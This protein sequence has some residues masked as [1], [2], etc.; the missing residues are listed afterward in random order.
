MEK[1]NPK[2]QKELIQIYL[3][4]FWPKWRREIFGELYRTFHPSTYE[5]SFSTPTSN[6]IDMLDILEDKA[7]QE[8]VKLGLINPDTFNSFPRLDG[9]LIID[10]GANLDWVHGMLLYSVIY[11]LVMDFR[12]YQGTMGIDPNCEGKYMND[13][14]CL[15]QVYEKLYDYMLKLEEFGVPVGE[16][17]GQEKLKKIPLVDLPVEQEC[18]GRKDILNEYGVI[19]E[20]LKDDTEVQYLL[21]NIDLVKVMKGPDSILISDYVEGLREWGRY[22]MIMTDLSPFL[23]DPE[24]VLKGELSSEIMQWATENESWPPDYEEFFNQQEDPLPYLWA[25][26]QKIR[27]A[28]TRLTMRSMEQTGEPMDMDNVNKIFKELARRIYVFV[29]RGP[30]LKRAQDRKRRLDEA[31]ELNPPV[32]I[33]DVIELLHLEDPYSPI[34]LLTKGIVVGFDKDPFEDRLLVRWIIDPD[35]PEFKNMPLYPSIDAYR[36][37]RSEELLEESIILNEQSTQTIDYTSISEPKFYGGKGFVF[38]KTNDKIRPGV[39]QLVLVGPT[40]N[41][42]TISIDSFE[43]RPGKYG[44]LQVNYNVDTRGD[45]DLLF[46]KLERTQPKEKTCNFNWVTNPKYWTR[47]SW[48]K[49]LAKV[50]QDSLNQMYAQYK[51]PDGLPTPNHIKNGFINVPGTE[52]HG[53]NHGWSILNFFQTNPLVRQILIKEYEKFVNNQDGNDIKYAVGCKFN[54]DEFINWIG[55]NKQSLFGMNSST[56]KE[57]VRNNQSSWKKGNENEQEAAKELIKLYDGWDV[58]YGG[59]PGIFRDALEGSDIRITN[60]ETGES[61]EVQVKPLQKSNDVYQKD[62]KWWV[63][64]GW[65]KQYPLSVTHYLFGPSK[66]SEKRVAIFKNEGQG[67]THTK[68]GE[69]MVFNSPP[70]HPDVINESIYSSFWN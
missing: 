56:F 66:D 53:T 22:N 32:Q 55:T 2:I 47:S 15:K 65:L 50:I 42:P 64:S 39:E 38:L 27:D 44:G 31:D 29:L 68:E 8:G 57:M 62:G 52:A 67:P 9:E 33:G 6:F 26:R 1:Y 54:I 5:E 34:P 70:L 49:K 14:N 36:L 18:G 24:T 43:A 45:F 25:M 28:M 7:V 58:I 41:H 3:E 35:G 23:T 46:K 37:V 19:Q 48:R 13:F 20:A 63:K 4:K 16:L 40:S 60:K 61:M 30:H 12:C 11:D 10:E 17:I 69:F 59:E 51:A 21:D